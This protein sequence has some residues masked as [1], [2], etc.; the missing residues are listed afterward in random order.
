MKVSLID[1]EEP[2]EIRLRQI[3]PDISNRLNTTRKDVVRSIEEH[4]IRNYRL[5]DSMHRRLENLFAGRV[6]ITIYGGEAPSSTGSSAPRT[7]MTEGS[8]VLDTSDYQA[9]QSSY[10]ASSAAEEATGSQPLDPSAPA[11]AHQMSRTIST[12]PDLYREWMFGLGSAPA[13]QALEDAYGAKWRLSQ[14][15]RVFFGRRK[16]IIAEIQRRQALEE[17]PE[18]VVEELELVRRRIKTTLHELQKWLIKMKAQD[19]QTTWD[20]QRALYDQI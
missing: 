9:V 13:I 4:G 2:D 15:E 20:R 7:M 10:A 3:I 17:A 1:I 16:I 14:A 12:V 18:T 6:S 11:P 5:L 19:L 8:N